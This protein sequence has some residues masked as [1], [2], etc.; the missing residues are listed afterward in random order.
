MRHLLPVAAAALVCASALAQDDSKE[1]SVEVDGRIAELHAASSND[2][3]VRVVLEGAP[4]LCGNAFINAYLNAN[5]P[6]FDGMV[7]LLVGAKA[8]RAPITLVSK[9]DARGHCKI[10]YLI[11]RAAPEETKPARP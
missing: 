11:L 4:K 6:N 5:D 2:E 7:S 1:P 3:S 10:Q 8:A 9:K